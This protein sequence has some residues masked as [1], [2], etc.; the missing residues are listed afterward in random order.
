MK[1]ALNRIPQTTY[2]LQGPLAHYLNGISDQWLKIAPAANP[3]ML[4][5]FR[6]RDRL[7]GATWCPGL[8]NLPASI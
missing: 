2:S 5:M 1:P 7:P 8:E 6:D 3:A 4:E